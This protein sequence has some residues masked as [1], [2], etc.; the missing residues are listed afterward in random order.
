M[1]AVLLFGFVI[2]ATWVGWEVQATGCVTDFGIFG[3]C[4]ALPGIESWI[5]RAVGAVVL[6]FIVSFG[7]EWH[8]QQRESENRGQSESTHGDTHNQ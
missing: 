1:A 5:N 7:A 8:A 2:G 3:R 4:T 6:L